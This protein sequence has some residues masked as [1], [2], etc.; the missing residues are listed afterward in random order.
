MGFL[1]KTVVLLLIVTVYLELAKCPK[2]KKGRSNS[3]PTPK[4]SKKEKVENKKPR[5]QSINGHTHSNGQ[6]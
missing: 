2:S 4:N 1:R 5:S 6:E 3:E